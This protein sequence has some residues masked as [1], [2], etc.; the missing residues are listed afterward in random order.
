MPR[1]MRPRHIDAY[2]A[3]PRASAARCR[4]CPFRGDPCR[5][6]LTPRTRVSRENRTER[7]TTPAY[8]LRFQG[9]RRDLVISQQQPPRKRVRRREL[10]SFLFRPEHEN[11]PADQPG[12]MMF[13]EVEAQEIIDVYLIIAMPIRGRWGWVHDP[14]RLTEDGPQARWRN[15]SRDFD[16][17]DDRA[18]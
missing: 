13:V 9:G 1:I 15:R 17:V 14:I 10:E 6:S 18:M 3:T 4:S 11:H 8:Q 12:E 2:N 5:K 16:A 7:K